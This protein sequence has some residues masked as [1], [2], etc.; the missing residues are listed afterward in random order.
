MTCFH[1]N[2]TKRCDCIACPQGECA[3]CAKRK[4]W[5]APPDEK[6]GDG[7]QYNAI[8]RRRIRDLI[9]RTNEQKHPT[10]PPLGPNFTLEG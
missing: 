10:P 8:R 5:N 4:P 2:G 9:K 3:A 1:C 7:G 6:G